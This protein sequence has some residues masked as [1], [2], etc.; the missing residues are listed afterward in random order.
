[1]HTFSLAGIPWKS[2]VD[3]LVDLI[4]ASPVIV[5]SGNCLTVAYYKL[6]RTNMSLKIS[7]EICREQRIIVGQK[8]H[9]TILHLILTEKSQNPIFGAGF[10]QGCP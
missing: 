9:C 2:G 10:L 3:A 7:A 8:N 5:P 1:M 4:R 6:V